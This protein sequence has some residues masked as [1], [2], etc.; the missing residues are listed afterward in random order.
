M[1]RKG[2]FFYKPETIK[3]M[4]EVFKTGLRPDIPFKTFDLNF[5]DLEFGDVCAEEMLALLEQKEKK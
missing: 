3:K 1:S 2:E 4:R 5:D